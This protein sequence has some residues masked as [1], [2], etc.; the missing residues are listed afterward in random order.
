MVT[1]ASS[2]MHDAMNAYNAMYIYDIPAKSGTLK[3]CYTPWGY[4]KCLS[5]VRNVLQVLKA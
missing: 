1:C 5:E 2:A 4:G 3:T